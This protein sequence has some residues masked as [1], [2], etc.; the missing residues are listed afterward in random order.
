MYKVFP[1]K[2][3]ENTLKMLK[4][5]CPPPSVVF[6]L[7]V[8]NPFSEIMK[9][10]NYKV[11]NTKGEDL[12]ENPNILIPNDVDLVTGFEILEHLV[13]PYPLLKN[14]KAKRILLT[15]PIKMWF[16]K[17][18]RSKT[19]SFDRHYHEF[20]PWQFDWL[21]EKSGWKIIRKEFWKN[22]SNKIGIRPLLRNFT[23]RYYAVYAERSKTEYTN[24]YKGVLN[25]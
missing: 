16:A 22:P 2:R 12:D 25:L 11:Y 3:Y 15:V 8:V 20:E 7:G 9:E 23:N 17:A 14:I 6:D 24:Y 18:Y 19:D 1:K 5:V 13:S 21:L 10:N 4:S